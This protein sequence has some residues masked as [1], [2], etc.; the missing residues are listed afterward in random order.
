MSSVPTLFPAPTT[1]VRSALFRAQPEAIPPTEDLDTL[2]EELKVLKMRSMER[3]KK[4]TEDLRLIEDSIRRIKEREKGK[5]KVVE[6][7][8]KERDCEYEPLSACANEL[9][10]ARNFVP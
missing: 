8:K 6:K 2:Q 10:V 9:T 1:T 5:S 7:I 3:A 4:A